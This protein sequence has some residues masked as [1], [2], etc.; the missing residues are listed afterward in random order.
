MT[1]QKLS[2]NEELVI[3]SMRTYMTSAM[4]L[5]FLLGLVVGVTLYISFAQFG[6]T[7]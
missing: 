6:C 1:G 2:R 7:R 3:R 5:M 4:F